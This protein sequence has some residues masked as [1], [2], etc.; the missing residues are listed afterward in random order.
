MDELSRVM[1]TGRPFEQQVRDKQGNWFLLRILPYQVKEDIGGCVLTLI[2]LTHLKRAEAEAWAKD[3]QLSAILQNSPQLVFIEDLN[4]RYLVTDP[5][6]KEL[7]GRDPIGQTAFDVFPRK[8]AEALRNLDERVRE[9][10][11]V[12][13][14]VVIPHADGPHTYLVVKFPLR[15]ETGRIVGVGGIKTDV[16]RLKRAEQQ[17]REA[18]KHRDR[19]L[20]M[21]SH[22]LRNPLGAIV[23][24]TDVLERTPVGA[25]AHADALHVLR[26]Q[27]LQM[28]RLL[29]DLLD[30]ARITQSKIHL[31]QT[32][33]H[34]ARLIHEA[35]RVVQPVF[36]AGERSLEVKLPAEPLAVTGDS[37]RLQQML[38]NLLLNGAKYTSVGGRVWVEL[39]KESGEAVIRIRD[40]GVGIRLEMLE[41]VFDLFVQ[42]DDTLHRS[43][44]GLGV[45]LTL[46]RSIATLHGGRVQAHSAGLGHGSEFVVRLPLAA[47]AELPEVEGRRHPASGP[48]LKIL[49]VED[50]DDSRRMLEGLLKLDG[51][52]VQVAS[53][54]EEGLS[55]I[56]R[57]RP[58]V[59]IVDI[60]LPTLNG[61][62]VARR[63]RRLDEGKGIYLVALTGYG[64]AEDRQAVFDAG[65]DEHLVKPLKR[66]DLERALERARQGR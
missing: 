47:A 36:E 9:G 64:Q 1:N 21:L 18:V 45:G 53:D 40:D 22:E 37:A 35:V 11:T 13:D 57:E 65:F 23:N 38:V 14:E 20:A 50:N 27:A 59:A 29:D 62:E 49:I 31:Q 28:S 61:Y 46:V 25:P 5:T 32:T 6:F 41:K 52:E 7:A 43:T 24:A 12:E 15:D 17:T 42:G 30:I 8:T 58:A 66:G 63:V 55:A 56:Q 2:D 4:G 39:T 10:Q 54:G 51:H 16:T 26:G 19:F 48:A 34:L 60:G 44:S 3:Q 33:V